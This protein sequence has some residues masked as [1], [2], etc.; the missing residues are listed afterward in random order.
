LTKRRADMGELLFL[1]GF[2]PVC[3]FV[4]MVLRGEG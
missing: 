1:A 2:V 3:L 4:L